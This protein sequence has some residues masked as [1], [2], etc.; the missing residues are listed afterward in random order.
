MAEAPHKV[1]VVVRD[2]VGGGGDYV[3]RKAGFVVG[4]RLEVDVGQEA[5]TRPLRVW[6]KVEQGMEE[7]PGVVF[8]VMR[9]V[10]VHIETK[11]GRGR[12]RDGGAS[13]EN[14]SFSR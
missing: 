3:A 13:K 8:V 9:W 11:R 4:R 5:A 6:G 12:L 14:I 7:A 10:G 2:A 1:S